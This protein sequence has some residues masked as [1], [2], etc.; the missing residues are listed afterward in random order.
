M[1]TCHLA[2]P[3]SQVEPRRSREAPRGS[4]SPSLHPTACA[5]V[6]PSSLQSNGT[7]PA[8][9]GQAMGRCGV[10]SGERMQAGATRRTPL[11]CRTVTHHVIFTDVRINHPSGRKE[12]EVHD[13]LATRAEAVTRR[14]L[15]T[16][17]SVRRWR[18]RWNGR[19]HGSQDD[20]PRLHC[21]CTHLLLKLSL[22]R[23][24]TLQLEEP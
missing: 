13:L 14:R 9:A 12:A 4:I 19:W 1:T 8:E 16:V 24:V 20:R 6:V 3:G 11:H 15:W 18:R 21:S 7:A 22:E 17:A 2:W 10:T 5:S 23:H